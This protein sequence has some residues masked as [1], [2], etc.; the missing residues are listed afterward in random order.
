MSS[1]RR[2]PASSPD[3]AASPPRRTPAPSM[4]DR[5]RTSSLRDRRPSASTSSAGPSTDPPMPMWR[6]AGDVAERAGLDRIDQRA[7]PLPARGGEIDLLG[8]AAAALGDMGRRAA[9]A[10]IDDLAGE[11]GF[12]TRRRSRIS[13][14]R[15]DK[16]FDQRLVEMGFRPVEIESGDLE[17][18]P[19]RAGRA[20]PRTMHRAASASS[21]SCSSPSPRLI[22]GA[23][24]NATPA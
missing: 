4:L 18:Q 13:S 22:I 21:C 15:C 14:A 19:A 23:A 16:R 12:A 5:K 17:A 7:H 6:I 8:R 24:A 1:T 3:R 9:L 10:R 2:R 11:Q 20:R